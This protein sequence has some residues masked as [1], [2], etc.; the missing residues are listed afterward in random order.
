[1]HFS[2]S[3]LAC[4]VL[5]SIGFLFCFPTLR[6]LPIWL[7]NNKAIEKGCLRGTN[8]AGTNLVHGMCTRSHTSC[9]E[10]TFGSL[11][12]QPATL[13]RESHAMTELF[14]VVWGD[15]Q[16]Y[17]WIKIFQMSSLSLGEKPNGLA[18]CLPSLSVTMTAVWCVY[19]GNSIHWQGF[20]FIFL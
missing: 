8:S 19:V 17:I 1:M 11:Y 16:Q 3:R 9:S 6:M 20:F 2:R 15:C 14:G 13:T 5:F 10:E 7:L 4:S 18:K 12:E